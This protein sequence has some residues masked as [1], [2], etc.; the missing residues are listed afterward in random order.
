LFNE[1]NEPV[2]RGTISGMLKPMNN[3]T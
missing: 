3:E 2:C 1:K